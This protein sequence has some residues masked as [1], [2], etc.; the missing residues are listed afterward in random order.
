MFGHEHIFDVVPLF[1]NFLSVEGGLFS[2]GVLREAH[3]GKAD[4]G[5]FFGP[6]DGFETKGA[7]GGVF[8]S[9]HCGGAFDPCAPFSGVDADRPGGC[10]R[11]K[12]G[13]RNGRRRKGRR[14]LR[15]RGHGSAVPALVRKPRGR[16]SGLQKNQNSQKSQCNRA[17]GKSPH[18]PRFLRPLKIIVGSR[19]S[20]VGGRPCRRVFQSPFASPYSFPDSSARFS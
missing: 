10:R 18:R 15:S 6:G 9:D 5:F 2:Q 8:A 4:Q 17:A 7:R 20:R 16:A 1:R 14:G 12:G 13:E 19:P 11:R 3:P